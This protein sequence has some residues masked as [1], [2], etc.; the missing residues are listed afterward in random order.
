R[1]KISRFAIWSGGEP[2]CEARLLVV[3]QNHAS[4]L[5]ILSCSRRPF[6]SGWCEFRRRYIGSY[7]DQKGIK[8][9]RYRGQ[10]QALKSELVLVRKSCVCYARFRVHRK[11]PALSSEHKVPN[12]KDGAEVLIT[13]FRLQ[14]MMNP[15]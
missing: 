2:R 7:Q 3:G 6:N 11:S 13:M 1:G 15:V 14:G 9:L 10:E 12:A 4:E 5:R 8:Q